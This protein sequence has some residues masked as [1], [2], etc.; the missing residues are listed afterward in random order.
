MAAGIEYKA[1]GG[2]CVALKPADSSWG[3]GGKPV[4][5]RNVPKLFSMPLMK[6]KSINCVLYLTFIDFCIRL[7]V[8]AFHQIL[9]WMNKKWT[10]GMDLPTVRSVD[11]ALIDHI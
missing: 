9:Y 7:K 1:R 10:T 2:K 3:A 6:K 4:L 11:W 5:C 8:L